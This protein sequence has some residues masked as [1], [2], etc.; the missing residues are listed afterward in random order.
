MLRDKFGSD[1]DI[2]AFRRRLDD[3]E[4]LAYILGEWYFWDE[5]YTV[6]PDVLIPRA[7]TEH[8]VEAAIKRLDGGGSLCDLC[9]GSGCIGISTLCHTSKTTCLSCDISS[10]AL[11]ITRENAERNGVSGRL[12]TRCIDVLDRNA[13]AL[14]GS[15]DAVTS[16]PPYIRTDVIPT[17]ETVK[18]E[19]VLALDGGSD[20]LVFYRA[21]VS[22]F[23]LL[24][25]AGGVML[26]EI[27]FD[28]GNDLRQLCREAGLGCV[29]KKDYSQNDRVAVISR[30]DP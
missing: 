13:L 10:A 24:V 23:D 11:D 17:L 16:N 6:T 20:G 18:R 19:P 8:V 9:C 26:L 29:I 4:P 21:L 27:G 30:T 25:K 15:F 5:E 14:L 22:A 3:G 1:C 28:Q 7:D 2:E 12:T